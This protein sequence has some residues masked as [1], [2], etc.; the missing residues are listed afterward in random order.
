M[1]QKRAKAERKA[2]KEQ[3]GAQV[4]SIIG[5]KFPKSIY[6]YGP[7][8]DLERVHDVLVNKR[9]WF[10]DPQTLNDPFDC[11][12]VPDLS[13]PEIRSA[14]IPHLIAGYE[15]A[16][17]FVRNQEE[18]RPSPEHVRAYF[19]G[20]HSGDPALIAHTV[21]TLAHM[22]SEGFGVCCLTT[23][24]DNLPMWAHYADNHEGVCY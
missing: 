3:R 15:G 14:W 2:A 17:E 11:R 20:I 13:S 16:P 21:K 8:V 18:N 12:V 19:E 4:D 9:I 24:S 1:S 7:A 10:A 23:K 22:A 5:G 6:K